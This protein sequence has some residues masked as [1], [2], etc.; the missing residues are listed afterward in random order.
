V[1]QKKVIALHKDNNSRYPIV[2]RI[3]S[4]KEEAG[5]IRKINTVPIRRELTPARGKYIMR[6]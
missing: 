2:R 3:Y 4:S 5:V 6:S 1:K